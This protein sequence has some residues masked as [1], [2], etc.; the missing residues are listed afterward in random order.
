MSV[1]SDQILNSVILKL[2]VQGKTFCK[3]LNGKTSIAIS[4]ANS[5]INLM[6]MVKPRQNNLLF[7]N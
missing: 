5:V 4:M 7:K 2:Q 1:K 3:H 6:A